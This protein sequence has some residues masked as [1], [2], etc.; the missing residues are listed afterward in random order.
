MTPFACPMSRSGATMPCVPA[1][2]QG[3]DSRHKPGR[4]GRPQSRLIP[5][6][7]V[8]GAMALAFALTSGAAPVRDDVIQFSAEMPALAATVFPGDRRHGAIAGAASLTVVE[9]RLEY[10]P[11]SDPGGAL[12]FD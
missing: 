4:S 12:H 9:T 5:P 11:W 8:D 2:P 7:R 3:R 6:I 1:L 10:Q